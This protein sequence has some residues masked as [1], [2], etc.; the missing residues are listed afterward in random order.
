[1]ILHMPYKPSDTACFQKT[2]IFIHDPKKIVLAKNCRDHS[3]F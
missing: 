3:Y 2:E 1:M